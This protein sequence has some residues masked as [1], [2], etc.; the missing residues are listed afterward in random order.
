[1]RHESNENRT[2][3]TYQKGTQKKEV[4]GFQRNV[5]R[6]DRN[7]KARNQKARFLTR[8][9]RQPASLPDR[10]LISELPQKIPRLPSIT[11]PKKPKHSNS[12]PRN[13]TKLS[14]DLCPGDPGIKAIGG[15]AVSKQ[16]YSIWNLSFPQGSSLPPFLSRSI[17]PFTHPPTLQ[18]VRRQDANEEAKPP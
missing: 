7:L 12:I 15:P 16:I 14:S 5:S 11:P 6:Q 13:K 1:M 3:A 2:T 18:K 8:T 9:P 10:A 4:A 17:H